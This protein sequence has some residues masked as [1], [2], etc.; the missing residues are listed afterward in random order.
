M[1]ILFGAGGPAEG[2]APSFGADFFFVPAEGPPA[3][4]A[5]ACSAKYFCILVFSRFSQSLSSEF[6]YGVE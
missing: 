4:A 1:Y 3:E 5:F 2:P 6:L